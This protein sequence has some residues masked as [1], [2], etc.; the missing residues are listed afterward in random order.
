M[1][2]SLLSYRYYLSRIRYQQQLTPAVIMHYD[3]ESRDLSAW[4][5]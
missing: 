2:P 1:E 4:L 3:A 5:W